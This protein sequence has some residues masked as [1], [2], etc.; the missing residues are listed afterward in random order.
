M[1]VRRS[2]PKA[3]AKSRR[4][5][6]TGAGSGAWVKPTLPRTSVEKPWT[7]PPAA[8]SLGLFHTGRAA[9]TKVSLRSAGAEHLLDFALDLLEVH[10]LPIDRRESD[11]R[12]LVEVAQPVHHH[13]AD[14][15]A[16]DLDPT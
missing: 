4:A 7:S 3:R 15:S 1:L 13:L 6:I 14:L 2:R 10:D 8:S 11:V 5:S 16:R 9:R 12:H